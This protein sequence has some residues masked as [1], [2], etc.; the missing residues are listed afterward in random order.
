MERLS[1]RHR[2]LLES[3]ATEKARIAKDLEAVRQELDTS[4]TSADRNEDAMIEEILALEK[5]LDENVEQQLRQDDQIEALQAKLTEY[6]KQQ[7]RDAR[8]R[9]R[10]VRDVGKRFVTLY[11]NTRFHER[12]IEGFDDL[13]EDMK[14]RCEELIYQLDHDPDQ[15]TVKRKVFSKSR[16]TFFELV[17]AYRGRLY[18]RKTATRGV[19]VVT[20]GTKNSQERDL[21]L[22]GH[23]LKNVPPI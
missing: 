18:F 11:K 23:P 20:I 6:E 19:E 16:E 5:K 2:K 22:S 9:K 10:T 1:R 8:S 3:L 7:N 12:A 17:F 15:V 13:P 21:G 4:R 14:L